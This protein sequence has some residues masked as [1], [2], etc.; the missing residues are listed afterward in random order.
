MFDLSKLA[1]NT[2]KLRE[3]TQTALKIPLTGTPV[4]QVKWLKNNADLETD[5]HFVI[6]SSDNYT[7]MTVSS[8][9]KDDAGIKPNIIFAISYIF[10]SVLNYCR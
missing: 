3:G 8:V 6:R 7:S 5:T 1:N 9:S 10:T 2:F 4:P